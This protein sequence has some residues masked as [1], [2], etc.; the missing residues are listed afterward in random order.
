MPKTDSTASVSFACSYFFRIAGKA[1]VVESLLSKVTEPSAFRNCVEKSKT[2][3]P[4][5]EK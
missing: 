2:Y 4:C 5:S 1:P 3:I